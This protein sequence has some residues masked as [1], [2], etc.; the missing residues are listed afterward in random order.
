VYCTACFL[1]L[2]NAAD[3]AL[4]DLD[5]TPDHMGADLTASRHEAWEQLVIDK[6]CWSKSPIQVLHAFMHRA[7]MWAAL[8]LSGCRRSCAHTLMAQG[9]ADQ[10]CQYMGR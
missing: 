1:Q 5:D 2:F 9:A 10:W 3:P 6:V 8:R 4:A 7:C